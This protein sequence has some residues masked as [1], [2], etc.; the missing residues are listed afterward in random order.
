M[1]G[2]QQ[3]FK[4]S[5]PNRLGSWC[6]LLCL[7]VLGAINVAHAVPVKG[8]Y[9]AK[10]EVTDQAAS[11]RREAL[12]SMLTEV[13]GRV[14]GEPNPELLLPR[15]P[16][17]QSEAQKAERYL[18][19]FLYQ[20]VNTGLEQ[21]QLV[22]RAEFEPSAINR[23]IQ[24]LKLPQWGV[25]R[26]E[27]LVVLAWQGDG[28]REVLASSP[29]S[30]IAAQLTDELETVAAGAGLPI[31]LPLMDLQDQRA[32]PEQELRAGFTDGLM[33]VA[34]RYGADAVL[35]GRIK[36]M[37]APEQEPESAPARESAEAT[38]EPEGEALLAEE[39]PMPLAFNMRE[40][41][42]TWSLHQRN[43]TTRYA[44]SSNTVR[45]GFQ[46]GMW[47]AARHLAERYAVKGG[48]VVDPL[49]PEQVVVNDQA[50]INVLGINSLVDLK[51]VEK[52]LRGRTVVSEISLDTID[53]VAGEA[54]TSFTVTLK[55]SVAKLEQAL[56]VGR[57]LSPTSK[58]Q[59][60]SFGDAQ[61][62]ALDGS[63][64]DSLAEPVEN[65]AVAVE[66]EVLPE[67]EDMPE[68]WYRL[69]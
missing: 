27:L 62:Q 67:A 61:T 25:D 45:Q 51:R 64:N 16:E 11:T 43:E 20:R 34:A 36:V 30:Q 21:S 56:A 68:L 26:P 35:L 52:H 23:L 14:V 58:P 47:M 37:D 28:R 42:M 55:G 46:A 54:L 44:D 63:V 6:A 66:P 69:F 41:E 48:V 4:S 40:S 15:W 3:L 50:R 29:S 39:A 60:E 10:A 2:L 12:P 1:S 31:A 13:F 22:L 32:M 24:R 18:A 65:A 7:L 49:A 53:Q 9:T 5:C 19:Q 57:L 17:L 33:D 59:L 8:L 38:A